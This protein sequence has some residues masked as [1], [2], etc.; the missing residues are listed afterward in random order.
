[1]G[2]SEPD[3]GPVEIA[4][5]DDLYLEV[6]DQL[7]TENGRLR[8]TQAALVKEVRALR[9]TV[10]ELTPDH[11]KGPLTAVPHDVG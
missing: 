6:I 2:L 11:P 4:L 5:A 8:L 10:A 9:A 3:A 7:S 1:M